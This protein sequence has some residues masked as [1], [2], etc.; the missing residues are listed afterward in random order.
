MH[1]KEISPEAAFIVM[2]AINVIFGTM[3]WKWN[4]GVLEPVC[5]DIPQLSTFTIMV[6]N[7]LPFIANT[8]FRVTVLL[9]IFKLL[10]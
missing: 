6:L 5:Y 7:A 8:G 9:V 4:L 2:M 10:Y 3:A 1:S